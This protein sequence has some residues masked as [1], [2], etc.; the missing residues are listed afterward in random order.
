MQQPDCAGLI[1]VLRLDDE[2]ARDQHEHERSCDR[3]CGEHS[4]RAGSPSRP[5]AWPRSRSVAVRVFLLAKTLTAPTPDRRRPRPPRARRQST[6]GSPS[7]PP[8]LMPKN[9]PGCSPRDA[10]DEEGRPGG[11]SD[12]VSGEPAG[13]R[14]AVCRSCRRG[15][16]RSAPPPAGRQGRC[17]GETSCPCTKRARSRSKNHM[18]SRTDASPRPLSAFESLRRSHHRESRGRQP[19]PREERV[20]ELPH[21]EA[22]ARVVAFVRVVDVLER[23]VEHVVEDQSVGERRTVAH[24]H[25]DVPGEGHDGNDEQEPADQFRIAQQ[26]SV[27]RCVFAGA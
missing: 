19:R 22:K 25:R 26:R 13:Q 9:E 23:P 3:C 24:V 20:A 10:D 21:V 18:K 2:I 14:G 1:G 4:S 16:R 7:L 6:D 27:D 11:D 15:R 12:D 8:G 17:S 5:P